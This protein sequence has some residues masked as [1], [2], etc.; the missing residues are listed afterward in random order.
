MFIEEHKIPPAYK[1]YCQVCIIYS[2]LVPLSSEERREF[3][4]DTKMEQVHFDL[5]ESEHP[6]S[7]LNQLFSFTKLYLHTHAQSPLIYLR[8]M[9]T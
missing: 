9:K 6:H 2:T 3:L 4:L 8:H 1:T 5:N 7:F